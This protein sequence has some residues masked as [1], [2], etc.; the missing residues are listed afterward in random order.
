MGQK[1][2]FFKNFTYPPNYDHRPLGHPLGPFLGQKSDF[3]LSAPG[4]YG[5]KW[6]PKMAKK[7]N[8][9]LFDSSLQF[10]H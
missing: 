1:N 2:F 8:S 9:K 3:P 7:L 4:F 10:Q 5:A 6:P